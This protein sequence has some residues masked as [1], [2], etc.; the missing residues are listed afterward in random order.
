M[1]ATTSTRPKDEPPYHEHLATFD[2]RPE[3]WDLAREVAA[4][5]VRLRLTPSYGVRVRVLPKPGKAVW[6]VVEV[7]GP[8]PLPADMQSEIKWQLALT[9]ENPDGT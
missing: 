9:K 4:V 3:A 1:T 5:L 6:H 7:C 8:G 2:R